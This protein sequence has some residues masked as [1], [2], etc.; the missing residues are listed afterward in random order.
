MKNR[1]LVMRRA[2]SWLL[3]AVMTVGMLSATGVTVSAETEAEKKAGQQTATASDAGKE[4]KETRTEK[5]TQAEPL[6]EDGYLMDGEITGS[7]AE[8]DPATA[9]DAKRKKY[10][11]L[12]PYFPNESPEHLEFRVL[13]DYIEENDE[14]LYS[15]ISRKEDDAIGKNTKTYDNELRKILTDPARFCYYDFSERIGVRPAFGLLYRRR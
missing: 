10:P 13:G 6:D 7:M 11:S 1:R 4:E 5:E 2:M 15:F 8:A 3:T 12:F 14:I 9:S